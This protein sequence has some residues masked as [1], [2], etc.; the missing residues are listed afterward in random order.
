MSR[1]RLGYNLLATRCASVTT[2]GAGSGSLRRVIEEAIETAARRLQAAEALLVTAGAGMGV[3]SGLPD[4]RGDQG[5]WKA[6]PPYATMGLSFSELASPA[7]FSKDVSLAWGFYGHRLNLYR[8]TQPH[9]GFERLARWGRGKRLGAF[10]FTTNVDGQF[11]RSG[12]DRER[13]VECHGAIDWMQCLAGCGVG[14]FPSPAERVTVDVESFRAAPPYPSCPGCGKLARPNILMFGDGA[15][16]DSRSDQQHHRYTAWLREVGDAPLAIVE[17]GAGSS[18]PTARR[19]GERL[20]RSSSATL[21]RINPRDAQGPSGTISIPL[22]A[23]EA[24]AA[25]DRAL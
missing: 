6:Y 21:I 12:W 19:T 7:W 24:L 17:C 25:L 23:G 2:A 20:A 11:Q 3:D 13:I 18:I 5:F 14:L 22:G 9:A 4:F 16:D 8:A 1:N 10:V 15:W